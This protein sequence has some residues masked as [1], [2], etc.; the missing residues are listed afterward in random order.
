MRRTLRTGEA[1]ARGEAGFSLLELLVVIGLLAA[2]AVAFSGFGGGRGGPDLQQV[3]RELTQVLRVARADAIRSGDA[4]SVLF[5]AREGRFGRARGA[6]GALTKLPEALSLSVRAAAETQDA[7]GRL[8]IVFFPDGSS[9][10]GVV[11]LARRDAGA[12]PMRIAV[13]W[14]TGQVRQVDPADERSRLNRG[15]PQR[16]RPGETDHG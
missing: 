11:T 8:A 6:A 12:A 1:S 7:A 3:A 16:G 14:L 2:L 10:G 15:R 4:V 13:R 5:D 9:T